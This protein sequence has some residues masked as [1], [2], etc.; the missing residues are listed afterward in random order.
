MGVLKHSLYIPMDEE[1]LNLI[2]EMA[3]RDKKTPVE[4]ARKALR[5][6]SYDKMV[7]GL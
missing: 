3:K 1:L 2:I 5:D 6:Y 7:R 4:F